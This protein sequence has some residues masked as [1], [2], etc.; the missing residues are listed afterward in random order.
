MSDST[1]PVVTVIGAG[2]AGCEAALQCA[3]YGISVRLLEM[4]PLAM[5]PAHQTDAPAELVCSNSLK[6]ESIDNA[7]GLLKAELRTC[8][9]VLLKC[10]EQ[11]R[12]PGGKALVVDRRQFSASVEQALNR[13]GIQI[14]RSE[15]REISDGITIIATGPLTSPALA[16]RLIQLLG[17]RQLFF[18]DAI[19]PIVAADSIDMS[20]VFPG[21]R[22]GTGSDYLNCPLTEA[23]YDRLTAELVNAELHPIHDFEQTPFFEGC[24]PIEEMARRG[25]LT[26]AFGPLKPVGLRTPERQRPFAVVQLRREN[27][28]GTMFNLVGFQTR[29]RRSEQERVFRLIPGLGHAVFLRYGSIHRNTYINSPQVLLPTLQTRVRHDLFVAGQLTGVEGYVE[30]IAAGLV[31]G[32]N[33]ARLARGRETVCWPDRTMIGALLRY[34]TSPNPDF[35]PMNANFGLLSEPDSSAGSRRLRQLQ[36]QTA[37][38]ATEA[39]R[40]KLAS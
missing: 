17:A 2:L 30:S 36:V 14:V 19:A 33:A 4:R 22:Y 39:H 9:S 12:I 32:I 24:L 37:L 3:R 26:L 23:E 38:A 16:H 13:A 27:A 7:H 15:V 25:R 35:Q 21:T 28:C 5:T 18:Y 34:I 31:A 8:G 20:R 11:A 10:A 40:H 6:S 29:L 1:S